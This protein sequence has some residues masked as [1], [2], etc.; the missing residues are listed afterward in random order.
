ML[1]PCDDCKDGSVINERHSVLC[2]SHGDVTRTT[3]TQYM[4]LIA[5]ACS[6]CGLGF[7]FLHGMEP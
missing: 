5:E 2:K 3:H 4:H 7:E 6:Q 1:P